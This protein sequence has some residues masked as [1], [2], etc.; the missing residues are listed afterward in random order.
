V[1][2]GKC[3]AAVD[4]ADDFCTACGSRLTREPGDRGL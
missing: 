1:T 2:C 3:G 4:G